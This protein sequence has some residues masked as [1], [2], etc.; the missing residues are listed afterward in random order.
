MKNDTLLAIG[1]FEKPQRLLSFH[2]PKTSGI[3]SDLSVIRSVF[4]QIPEQQESTRVREHLFQKYQDKTAD[5]NL[6]LYSAI[7]FT[8][9][10]IVEISENNTN[11]SGVREYVSKAAEFVKEIIAELSQTVSGKVFASS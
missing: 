10:Q 9:T 7:D 4:E 6:E 3:I 1:I 11:Q 2:E 5:L 8:S